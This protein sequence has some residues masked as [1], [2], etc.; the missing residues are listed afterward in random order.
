L[1]VVR[2]CKAAFIWGFACFFLTGVGAMTLVLVR[3]GAPPGYA[4][5]LS[6]AIAAAFWI[7]ALGLAAFASS[8]SCT[9]V[10]LNPGSTVLFVQRYPFRRTVHTLSIA[11][12]PAAS[13][14]TGEDSEGDPYFYARTVLPD[15]TEFDLFEGHDRNGCERVV[16]RFEALR[17]RADGQQ[18]D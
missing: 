5:A 4:P 11:E 6:F 7:G 1:L 10:R 3:D 8:R 9:H 12:L 2:N 16:E 15:G 17:D 18:V 14:V 13:V